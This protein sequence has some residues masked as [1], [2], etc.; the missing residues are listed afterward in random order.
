MDLRHPAVIALLQEH[1]DWMH[2]ISPPESVHALDL[3]ALRQP[4][5]AFWTLWDG[6]T[7]TGCGA[8]RV[9]DATHGEVKSMRTAQTHLRRGVAAT[10]LEHLLAEARGR[11]YTRL[12]LE[13]GSMDYFAPARALYARAGFLPCA[14]F[15]DYA[16][17]PNSVFMT[18]AL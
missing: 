5:I 11:G 9:L 16:E 15:G 1:L 2:R 3:D 10:M 17:D 4:D 12:S 13:T 18:R 8:L 6:E 14:P 7:L